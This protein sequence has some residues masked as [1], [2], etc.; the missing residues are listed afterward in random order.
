MATDY[1]SPW[2]GMPRTGGQASWGFPQ[3]PD[4]VKQHF[5]GYMNAGTNINAG[6]RDPNNSNLMWQALNTLPGGEGGEPGNPYGGYR[7]YQPSADGGFNWEPGSEG[8][9]Y[10]VF[11]EDGSY[12]GTEGF[13]K[14]TASNWVLALPLLAGAAAMAAGAGGAAGAG[15]GEA[16]AGTGAVAT[17]VAGSTA[18]GTD[19]GMLGAGGTA[20][21]TGG[22]LSLGGSGLG[23]S[24]TGGGLGLS[25][26]GAGGAATG[27]GY[28]TGGASGLAG[29]SGSLLGPT[30]AAAAPAA[31]TGGLVSQFLTKLGLPASTLSTLK[32]FA[33]V[34]G[35]V[36][37]SMGGSDMPTYGGGAGGA[38]GAG[39][40]QS[41][42]AKAFL[43]A[44]LPYVRNNASNPTGSS[45]WSRG[46]DGSWNLA[47]QPNAVNQGIYG[48][49]SAKLYD[50]ID[51]NFDQG[52]KAPAL[53][54]D[55]RGRYSDELAKTIYDRSQGLQANDIDKERAAM[56]ARMVEQGF[57]PGNEGYL[58]EMN[59]WEDN[60]GEMRGKN[61][62]DA[63]IAAAT[64]AL[65]E[66]NFT[67]TSRS[68]G[69]QNT[70]DLQGHIASIL[71]GARNNVT[72]GLKSL[73]SSSSAPSGTPGSVTTMAD[74]KW[75]A[76]L[77]NYQSENAQRNDLIR[78]LMQWG[79]A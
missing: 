76:D 28:L 72:E 66:A 48:D 74:N 64:Q 31:A 40:G 53:I 34:A 46:P 29:G 25:T 22:G 37:S 36:A 69:Q 3:V 16:A 33:P 44:V 75:Q 79:L 2:G 14:P 38:G 49:A 10:D 17:P 71:A 8:T 39:T 23:L 32:D 11:K 57:V 60:L 58:N 70:I 52:A 65:Q 24:G 50:F 19:L 13:G 63:Q 1:I 21:S 27:G 5:D 15:A 51:N 45:Q 9:N 43:E 73:T 26:G 62:M 4:Y 41:A 20:G 7:V 55:V 47:T 59:R 56:Q 68:K 12:A 6:F 67:N 77:A 61:A 35:A 54:D 18:V 42:E 78:A 30:A